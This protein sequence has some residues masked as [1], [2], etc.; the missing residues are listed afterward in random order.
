MMMSLVRQ[1]FIMLLARNVSYDNHYNLLSG[2]CALWVKRPSIQLLDKQ[3]QKVDH[4][5]P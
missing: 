5:R 4:A 1:I 2:S 3:S